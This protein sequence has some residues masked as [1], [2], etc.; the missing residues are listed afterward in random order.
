MGELNRKGPPGHWEPLVEIL[1]GLTDNTA[2][3]YAKLA[4]EENGEREAGFQPDTKA[5][6]LARP[7]PLLGLV[8]IRG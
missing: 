5:V 8:L 6:A 1:S 3:R 2:K 4:T 7:S